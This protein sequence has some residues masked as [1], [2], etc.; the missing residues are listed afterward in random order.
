M[1][2]DA[3]CESQH[4]ECYRIACPGFRMVCLGFIRQDLGYIRSYS[5]ICVLM[6]LQRART[7]LIVLSESRRTITI[8]VA[9]SIATIA[10]TIRDKSNPSELQEGRT[11]LKLYSLILTP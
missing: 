3:V 1:Q 9:A 11:L 7:N 2:W 10:T 6:S 8:I 4:Y 5:C